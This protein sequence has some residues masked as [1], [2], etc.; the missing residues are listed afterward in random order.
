M[1]SREVLSLPPDCAL[2]KDFPGGEVYVQ[3]S[4][5][6]DHGGPAHISLY[7]TPWEEVPR[8]PVAHLKVPMGGMADHE[9]RNALRVEHDD[10]LSES[11]YGCIALDSLGAVIRTHAALVEQA[12]EQQRARELTNTDTLELLEGQPA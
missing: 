8:V 11:D 2:R 9:V 6:E 1:S 4:G 10:R 7:D 12:A 5:V 3:M